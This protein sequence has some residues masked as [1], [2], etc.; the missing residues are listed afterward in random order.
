M[1]L[2]QEEI[3]KLGDE[4]GFGTPNEDYPDSYSLDYSAILSDAL[5]KRLSAQQKS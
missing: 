3:N 5:K 2:T 1:I 4:C